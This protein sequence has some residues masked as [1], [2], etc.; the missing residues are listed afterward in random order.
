[1]EKA[2]QI[3][4]KQ[5]TN[6]I[7]LYQKSYDVKFF[8]F[9]VL[10]SFWTVIPQLLMKTKSD[11]GENSGIVLMYYGKNE[12]INRQLYSMT[13]LQVQEQLVSSE[14]NNVQYRGNI[15][16]DKYL[17]YY[18]VDPAKQLAEYMNSFATG[19]RTTYPTPFSKTIPD[20]FIKLKSKELS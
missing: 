16:V 4:T 19:L 17:N 1:M 14:E 11:D 7:M 10:K 2:E 8:L 6:E 13:V 20:T 12:F 3:G 9:T 15:Y 5:E 18:T